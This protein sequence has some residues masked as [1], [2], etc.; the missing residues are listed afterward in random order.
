MQSAEETRQVA[1]LPRGIAWAS[2]PLGLTG[3][4]VIIYKSIAALAG[5]ALPL[6]AGVNLHLRGT[7]SWPQLA[8]TGALL[9]SALLCWALS[10]SGRR[11]IAAAL[12]IGLLWSTTTIYAFESGYGMHSAVVFAYLPC[13]LYTALFFGLPI[14]TAELALTVA[15]LV[16][17][18]FA[19]EGGRIG[20]ASEFARQ[21]TNFNF[22]LGVILTAAGTLIV[23]LVYHRR[24]ERDATSVAREAEQRR[25]AM[26]QAQLAGAQ[27]A[28][29][30]ARL[31][32][33]NDELAG[34]SRLHEQASVRARR[35]L[36]LYHDVI[37]KDLPASLDELRAAIAAPGEDVE[38]RLLRE[39]DRMQAV[40]GALADLRGQ[41]EPALERAHVDLSALA[42]NEA[43]HLRARDR[44]ARV[45][46]DVDPGMRA[47]GD[48]LQIFA[49]L[50]H[51]MKRAAVA[52]QSEP[53]A[54]VHVGSATL[55]GRLVYFVRDNGPGMDQAQC[56]SMFRS[57]E[58]G[59]PRNGPDDTV[60]IGL[61]SARRIAERHGGELF[62]QSAP[63]RGTTFFFSFAAD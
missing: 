21:G 10:R 7:V 50:H 2:T 31:Q 62:V 57:F 24:I 48:R 18:Y 14:A 29:A 36:D 15:A 16:L 33:L 49:L 39:I 37:A 54:L 27:L 61:V 38:A 3:G 41:A 22:L 42:H 1:G 59:N 47:R 51:L 23:S 17:M 53:N 13:V 34:R 12:L 28:T 26:E 5:I 60:D 4:D 35:D 46:V 30:N 19:E 32:S 20:G 43:R 40:V 9:A 11:E 55:E 25:Q 45:R 8:V 58:R 44:F 63:G 52:C 6:I 56:E